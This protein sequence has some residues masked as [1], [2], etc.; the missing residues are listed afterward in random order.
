M[1]EQTLPEVTKVSSTNLI[2]QGSLFDRV[3]VLADTM[4]N[5]KTTVPKHLQGCSADCAAIVMQAMQWGMNPFAVAQKTHLVNG[6][7]GYEAQ[8]VNA[9]LQSSGAIDG[10]PH[11][12]YQGEGNNLKCRVACTVAGENSLTWNEWLSISD[13]TTKNSP[14]WKTNPKQQM[15]YLQLKNWARLYTPGAI[16]GV[17]TPDELET[18]T[19]ERE[20]NPASQ[21]QVPTA[22]PSM[23][24]A[25]FKA[26]FPSYEAGI[27]SGRKTHDQVIKVIQ[28]KFTLTAEQEEAIR[29][30]AAPIN[31]EIEVVE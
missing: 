24:D 6:T 5:G 22:L 13:V 28:S 23:D 20:I 8:L 11:Y 3:M 16:L 25:K 18:V 21:A 10:R 29:S 9:V 30:V 19:P 12:E 27:L 2:M 15:G 31:G 14:L 17:Y 26:N 7:L 4:S 1:S